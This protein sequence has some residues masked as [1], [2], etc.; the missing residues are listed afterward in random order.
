MIG[1]FVELFFPKSC[2]SC[3]ER[4]RTQHLFCEECLL[5]IERLQPSER[6]SLCFME[7]QSWRC[8]HEKR[9]RRF[10][11]Q[12]S[13]FLECSVMDALLLDIH[14]HSKLLASYFFLQV[15]ELKWPPFQQVIPSKGWEKVGA[16]LSLFLEKSNDKRTLFIG[17]KSSD[18]LFKD[19]FFSTECFLLTFC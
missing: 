2:L 13:L 10:A 17:E 18:I 8:K 12:A 16:H 15:T 19:P 11:R 14:R 6:C 1:A 9:D 4:V 5:A 3:P 7:K